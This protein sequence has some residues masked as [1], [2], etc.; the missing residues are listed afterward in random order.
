[1]V[2]IDSIININDNLSNSFQV[3]SKL[4]NKQNVNF[5]K[6]QCKGYTFYFQY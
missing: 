1:M 2:L 5:N 6:I 3:L 4:A